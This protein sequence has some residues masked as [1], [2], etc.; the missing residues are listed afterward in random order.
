MG[1]QYY[2]CNHNGCG[3]HKTV[4]IP[5]LGCAWDDDN[6]EVVK[7][8]ECEVEGLMQRVCLNNPNHVEQQP[9]NALRHKWSEWEITPATCDDDGQQVRTC[10]R[11]HATQTEVLKAHGHDYD[12]EHGVVT[13]QPTKTEEGETTYYCKYDSSHT[14]TEPIAMLPSTILIKY[15][16]RDQWN[17]DTGVTRGDY[18][19]P[20]GQIEVEEGG[21][22]KVT[23]KTLNL[24]SGDK[25]SYGG[26]SNQE[27]NF[28]T[29]MENN[30][31]ARYYS[32]EVPVQEGNYLSTYIIQ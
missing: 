23:Y 6:W 9:I 10:G 26:I 29:V 4:L 15:H 3:A 24:Q 17:T 18:T 25:Y 20:D 8:A 31:T 27:I 7:P 14:I 28:T 1:E 16:L 19:A 32:V 30:Q 21:S 11:C 2:V 22:I 5:S 12:M 13:K